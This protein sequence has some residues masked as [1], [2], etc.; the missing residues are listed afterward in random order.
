MSN[1]SVKRVSR[2]LYR[3]EIDEAVRDE[4]IDVLYFKISR[5]SEK[6]NLSPLLYLLLTC[7]FHTRALRIR[8]KKGIL[9]KF[10][11]WLRHL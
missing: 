9:N 10:V 3:F 4:V 11:Y 5:R 2:F 1:K 8:R 7:D 6:A